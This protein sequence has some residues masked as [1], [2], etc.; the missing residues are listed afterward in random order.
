MSSDGDN[1]DMDFPELTP[2]SES[3][4]LVG[5]S[6]QSETKGAVYSAACRQSIISQDSEFSVIVL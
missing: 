5:G 3:D 1:Y 2:R 4:Y 6:V